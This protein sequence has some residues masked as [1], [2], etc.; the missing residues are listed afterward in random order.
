MP[1]HSYIITD[2]SVPAGTYDALLTSC[3]SCMPENSCPDCSFDKTITIN[4]LDP[5]SGTPSP[6][7]G[8]Q[9]IVQAATRS[10]KTDRWP[11]QIITKGTGTSGA[12]ESIGCNANCVYLIRIQYTLKT[13][14]AR[15]SFFQS[16]LSDIWIVERWNNANV[17]QELFNPASSLVFDYDNS[18][19]AGDYSDIND[20]KAGGFSGSPSTYFNPY[21]LREAYDENV[22]DVEIHC[23][24]LMFFARGNDKI[25]F[26]LA[27][28]TNINSNID[29]NPDNFKD[30]GGID[31]APTSDYSASLSN[32]AAEGTFDVKAYI[33]PIPGRLKL[34][35]KEGEDTATEEVLKYHP[36]LFS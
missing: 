19:F 22:N 11:Y 29:I 17:I 28:H 30:A 36:K 24:T 3:T 18:H 15:R 27:Q 31:T 4:G 1:E 13:S 10:S 35:Y 5:D 26:R 20:T 6:A 34:S 32:Y 16:G 9:E 25:K 8:S 12:I 21:G 2:P 33:R 14:S 7:W 23:G